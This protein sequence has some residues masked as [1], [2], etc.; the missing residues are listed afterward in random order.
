M[1]DLLVGLMFKIVF[2]ALLGYYMRKTGI[3]NDDFQKMLSNIMLSIVIPINVLGAGNSAFDR[4]LTGNL[5]WAT[6]FVL[7][8][9]GVG[10]AVLLPVRR[11]LRLSSDNQNMFLTLVLLSNIGY[12]GFPIIGSIYGV[13][14][15]LYTV[16]YNLGFQFTVFLV[17]MPLMGDRLPPLK[18]LLNPGVSF[19]IIAILIFV[20]PFRLPGFMVDTFNEVG[21]LSMPFSMFIAGAAL[22][23]IKFSSLWKEKFAWIVFGLRQLALPALAAAILWACGLRG[24][25]P[26]V[27]VVLTAMPAAAVNVIFAEKYDKDIPFAT[28]G[29][30]LGTTLMVVTLPV[31]VVACTW[32]FG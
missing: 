3:I 16:V 23:K 21:A 12:L 7:L 25:L 5:L 4:A 24:T 17:G 28:R 1:F 6:V 20:S 18:M 15:T 26:S 22:A 27:L 8:Y 19:P 14:G 10:T 31:W 32:L 30:V 29:M 9:Y 11:R 13:E 2:F